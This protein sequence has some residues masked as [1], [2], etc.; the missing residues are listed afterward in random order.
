MQIACRLRSLAFTL[1]T[2]AIAVCA[3][4][5]NVQSPYAEFRYHVLGDSSLLVRGVEAARTGVGFARVAYRLSN[6]TPKA[7][8]PIEPARSSHPSQAAGMSGSYAKTA[9]PHP[10]Q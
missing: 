7:A 9:R 5:S 2:L 10:A 6:V 8:G 3:I 1:A 4:A